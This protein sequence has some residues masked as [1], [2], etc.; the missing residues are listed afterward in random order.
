MP[1]LREVSDAERQAIRDEVRAEFP[2]D[3]MM[4]ELHFAR[5]MRTA[6]LR[7]FTRDERLEYLNRLLPQS[8]SMP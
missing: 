4:R 6:Q 5:A 7:D 1:N 8:T 3:E 2:D